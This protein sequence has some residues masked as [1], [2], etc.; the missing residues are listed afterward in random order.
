MSSFAMGKWF[1]EDDVIAGSFGFN[2]ETEFRFLTGIEPGICK[3]QQ[4]KYWRPI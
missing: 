4:K 2:G 1:L 3:S